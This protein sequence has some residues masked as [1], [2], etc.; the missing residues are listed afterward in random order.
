MNN[1]FNDTST[2]SPLPYDNDIFNAL[3]WLNHY[4]SMQNDYSS[5]LPYDND[6]MVKL[7]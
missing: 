1:T 6:N 4:N 5:L 2:S 7:L 3:T